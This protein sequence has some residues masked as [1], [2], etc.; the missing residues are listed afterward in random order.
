MFYLCIVEKQKGKQ[1]NL[2]ED[3][4]KETEQIYKYKICNLNS[5]YFLA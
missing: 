4:N 5:E 3:Y 1:H 2:I